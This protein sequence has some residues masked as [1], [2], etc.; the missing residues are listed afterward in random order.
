M[1]HEFFPV[2]QPLLDGN[3]KKYLAECIETGW[4]SSEAP[5]V[6]KF[7][8]EV[9]ARLGRKYHFPMALSQKS[10]RFRYDDRQSLQARVRVSSD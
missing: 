5:L 7:E 3:E 2:N 9:A 10:V 1:S 4:I 6:R 8:E